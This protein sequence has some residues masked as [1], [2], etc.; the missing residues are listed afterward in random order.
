MI[1][2]TKD[3]DILKSIA[4]NV[5][6]RNEKNVLISTKFMGYLYELTESGDKYDIFVQDRPEYPKGKILSYLGIDFYDNIEDLKHYESS[7]NG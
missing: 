1:D 6:S 4:I 7:Q 5:E 2:L 3:L